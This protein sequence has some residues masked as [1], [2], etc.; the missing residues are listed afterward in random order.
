MNFNEIISDCLKSQDFQKNQMTVFLDL[1]VGLTIGMSFF[2]MAFIY[3]INNNLSILLIIIVLLFVTFIFK[4]IVCKYNQLR[5]INCLSKYLSTV[6]DKKIE[7]GQL[8]QLDDDAAYMLMAH[9]INSTKTFD[10]EQIELDDC[11]STSFNI[12][13]AKQLFDPKTIS[14]F[15]KR[16]VFFSFN[17]LRIE[18]DSIRLNQMI[19][20]LFQK[21]ELY[22]FNIYNL[23]NKNDK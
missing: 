5:Y 16:V 20:S 2:Y 1:M 7:V 6:S 23:I 3:L 11:Q 15:G 9:I 17:K 19:Y 4:L 8:A 14:P 21:S 10:Q 22:H 18:R 12:E 13:I